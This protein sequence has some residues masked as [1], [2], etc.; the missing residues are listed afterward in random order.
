[1]ARQQLAWLP[2]ALHQRFYRHEHPSEACRGQATIGPDQVAR[3]PLERRRGP[4][5]STTCT[6]IL[7]HSI[8]PVQVRTK[9]PWRAD[10]SGAGQPLSIGRSRSERPAEYGQSAAVTYGWRAARRRPSYGVCSARVLRMSTVLDSGMVKPVRAAGPDVVAAPGR[11]GDCRQF[12]SRSGPGRRAPVARC[13]GRLDHPAD[14]PRV[15]ADL[16]DAGE[17]ILL[18]KLDRR[19]EQEAALRLAAGGHLGDRLD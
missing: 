2:H 13:S 16:A 4:T 11:G 1:M 8:R 7:C 19:G 14:D 6:L 17:A 15:L 10:L 12:S 18:E 3:S 5:W 9:P